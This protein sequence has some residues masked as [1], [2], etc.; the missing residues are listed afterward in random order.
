MSSFRYYLIHG[1]ER[2]RK[3][4]MDVQFRHNNIDA[5]TVTWVNHPNAD[6]SLPEGICIN[7]GLS[8]GQVAITYKHYLALKDVVDK[9]YDYAVIMEDNIEFLENANERIQVYLKQLPGDWDCLF[10]SDFYF[11]RYIESPLEK[12]R[13]VYRKNV[14]K[15]EQCAGASKGAHFYMV[16][17]KGARMLVDNFIPFSKASDHHFN[18][19]FS[20][21]NMNVF[22]ADPPNVHK[23]T[24]GSTWMPKGVIQQGVM[25]GI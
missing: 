22:W 4:F 5:S 7:P 10:D 3:V 16:S 19:I 25:Y 23:I 17:K 9:G 8:R 6:E 18:D 20:K 1:L 21:L 14:E 13:F 24:R 2:R 11:W 15:T 12:G